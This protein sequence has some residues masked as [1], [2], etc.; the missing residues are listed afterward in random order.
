MSIA[1]RARLAGVDAETYQR[2]LTDLKALNGTAESGEISQE[3]YA[4]AFHNLAGQYGVQ[5]VVRDGDR[6]LYLNP[7]SI[8]VVADEGETPL[9]RDLNPS[10]G[11]GTYNVPTRTWQELE[12]RNL[13]YPGGM[14][15]ESFL[16]GDIGGFIGDT[17]TRNESNFMQNLGGSF[18]S[19]IINAGRLALGDAFSAAELFNPDGLLGGYDVNYFDNS[20]N[21]R[22]DLSRS[23]MADLILNST[24]GYLNDRYDV[25]YGDYTPPENT[26]PED[27]PVTPG[28]PTLE[29]VYNPDGTINEEALEALRRAV[30]ENPF[31]IDQLPGLS[32]LLNGGGGGST[33]LPSEEE[34]AD[35]ASDEP[36]G[37]IGEPDVGGGGSGVDVPIEYD[38][39][40]ESDWEY[41]GGGVFRNRDTGEV[42]VDP[43]WDR[44]NDPY[45]IGG[46]YS[47]G[48]TPPGGGGTPQPEP[49]EPTLE[50]PPTPLPGGPSGPVEPTPEEPESPWGWIWDGAQWVFRNSGGGGGGTTPLPDPG[51]DGG[52]TTPV[53]DPG[54][55]G[56]GTGGGTG[57]GDGPGDGDGKG[58]GDK[59]GL[60]SILALLGASARTQVT[61][62]EVQA[63]PIVPYDFDSIFRSGFQEAGY[64]SP[65]GDRGGNTGNNMDAIIQ[66]L[67]ENDLSQQIAPDQL[68]D[69]LQR[70]KV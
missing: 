34:E 40:I 27:M 49:D 48:E 67:Q 61:T 24:R 57:T 12:A 43:D 29:G 38:P 52:G 44:N 16:S 9:D 1:D 20:G 47:R 3:Q 42:Y 13:L 33:D 46:V 54:A 10:T 4:R 63:Q 2:F 41:E 59:K 62:P 8:G 5:T 66:A 22:G 36:D 51:A 19:T 11:D 64:V 45:E 32:D 28:Q 25:D 50:W 68:F 14:P 39:N 70:M 23:E 55:G 31:L 18:L 56:G 15:H 21:P 7:G 69:V 58:D 60:D 53:P 26:P 6:I 30:E 37:A 17:R 35:E 65:Y